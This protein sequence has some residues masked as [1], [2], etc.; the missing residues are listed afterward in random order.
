MDTED[1][2][3]KISKDLET[4]PRI[5]PD[6]LLKQNA[7]TELSQNFQ[8]IPKNEIAKQK[9]QD[10]IKENQVLFDT[11]NNEITENKENLVENKENIVTKDKNIKSKTHNKSKED[12]EYEEM[13][14]YVKYL[15]K[16]MFYQE[17]FC[18]VLNF[19]YFHC[20]LI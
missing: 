6:F 3:E 17:N 11:T 7:L 13:V 12:S 20:I 4:I 8:L 16:Y 19:S 5:N 18:K 15:E 2:L 14:E 10:I 1:L 9:F